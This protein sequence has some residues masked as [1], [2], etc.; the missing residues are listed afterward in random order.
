MCKADEYIRK[1]TDVCVSTPVMLAELWV[2]E[3]GG[4]LF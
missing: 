3:A 2:G 1:S 4:A